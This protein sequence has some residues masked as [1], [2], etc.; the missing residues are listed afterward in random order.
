M[1]IV[2]HCC[3]LLLVLAVV[4]LQLCGGVHTGFG[5]VLS[6]I[7]KF[8]QH[9]SGGFR[10]FLAIDIP[11]SLDATTD[12]LFLASLFGLR[13]QIRPLD[14]TTFVEACRNPDGGFG[15]RPGM[16]SDVSSVRDAVQASQYLNIPLPT[17]AAQFLYSLL[18]STTGLF[19]ERVG[20]TG[21]LRST[22]FALQ[23]LE[24]LGQLDSPETQQTLPGIR[25]ALAKYDTSA[26][27]FDLGGAMPTVEANYYAVATAAWSGFFKGEDLTKWVDFVVSLQSGDGGFFGSADG[28]E[29]SVEAA[30]HAV[31]T[32]QRLL[33]SHSG[34]SPSAKIETTTLLNYLMKTSAHDLHTIAQ[35][36]MAVLLSNST[37]DFLQTTMSFKTLEGLEV[38]G[39][40]V[41]GT[42]LK[43]SVSIV[44]FGDLPQ[45]QLQVTLWLELEG[46]APVK[47]EMHWDKEIQQY[48]S[49]SLIDTSNTMGKLVLRCMV[50]HHIPS[51][52]Q[53]L[54]EHRQEKTV[55]LG[56]TIHSEGVSEGMLVHEGSTLTA[57]AVVKFTLQ[58]YNTSH[59]SISGNHQVSLA[60]LDA[61]RA[62]LSSQTKAMSDESGISQLEF[63][64]DLPQAAQPPAGRLVFQF[65]AQAGSHVQ[66]KAERFFNFHAKTVATQVDLR[67]PRTIGDDLLVSMTPANVGPLNGSM[68]PLTSSGYE[69]RKF[70]VQLCSGSVAFQSADGV[71][72]GTDGRY[73]FSL[74]LP[75]SLDSVGVLNA[76]FGY[77]GVGADNQLT[78]LEYY[79]DKS[80]LTFTVNQKLH[81]AALTDM[82]ALSD[83]H[84]GNTVH[85]RFHVADAIT[86]RQLVGLGRSGVSLVL[87]HRVQTLGSD[88][89][90]TMTTA[91]ADIEHQA[92][93]HISWTI[94]TNTAG[95]DGL[96]VLLVRD[97]DG[98]ETPLH[99]TDELGG[100]KPF[101]RRVSIDTTL[102]VTPS[103]RSTNARETPEALFGVEVKLKSRDQPLT[104]V[105]LE[106][107]V[108]RQDS[109]GPVLKGLKVL[110]SGGNYH[111]SWSAQ[112]SLAP[113]GRYIV[114]FHREN[115][116][117]GT[118][119]F[120]VDL[121]HQASSGATIPFSI[122]LVATVVFG[123]FY[124]YTQRQRRELEMFD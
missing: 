97:V 75:I 48:V 103:F 50:E 72:T 76:R 106:A 116:S 107:T 102:Q 104:G 62:T 42:K 65:V 3:I 1:T 94:D 96:L 66:A 115:N 6:E 41:Q 119:F 40:V 53:V 9:D 19:A 86:G 80:Q 64:Y 20:E 12:A 113:S 83:F 57:G 70:V 71:P 99:E 90:V 101:Q 23:A 31:S 51:L 87:A 117:V 118:P 18:D 84:Y 52:G 11:P 123:A 16:T 27:Y 69:H 38:T 114:E 121:N 33:Q 46:F 60:V 98:T 44:A 37:S 93:F 63:T 35:A 100:F 22:A 32:L 88:K 47:L 2:T 17:T 24:S 26:G 95:G 15:A 14:A 43:P 5:G 68:Q 110:E 108:K 36:H 105:K 7:S 4:H 56:M 49:K 109:I 89:W 30:V 10:R 81:I 54:A 124:M 25:K 91:N 58:I 78:P 67:K 21:D 111:V 73:Q 45:A 55:S 74:Q 77:R 34:S 122:E 112:H 92:G 8:Q 59:D 85:F 79:G 28:K 120:T 29:V 39:S 82:P 13:S 61:S